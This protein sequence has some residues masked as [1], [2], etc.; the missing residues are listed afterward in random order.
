LVGSSLFLIGIHKVEVNFMVDREGRRNRARQTLRLTDV[1]KVSPAVVYWNVKQI[2]QQYGLNGGV[3]IW[4]EHLL[5]TDRDWWILVLQM[6]PFKGGEALPMMM[7][8]CLIY[9]RGVLCGGSQEPRTFEK[10]RGYVDF[11]AKWAWI[12]DNTTFEKPDSWP[13]KDPPEHVWGLLRRYPVATSCDGRPDPLNPRGSGYYAV[14][15]I[16]LSTRS[17]L[18]RT[19]GLRT[20]IACKEQLLNR[21]TSGTAEAWPIDALVVA[22]APSPPATTLGP[23]PEGVDRR[24][25]VWLTTEDEVERHADR[26]EDEDS[27]EPS[28]SASAAA[29][30]QWMSDQDS[31]WA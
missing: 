29:V 22:P 19:Y 15:V 26:A 4:W 18:H 6:E 12:K 5:N 25:G 3:I 13:T 8:E 2:D 1:A 14:V 23:I 30:K 21:Y 11:A 16:E 28:E 31:G 9:E 10:P 7:M 24:N 20:V 17:I 27:S